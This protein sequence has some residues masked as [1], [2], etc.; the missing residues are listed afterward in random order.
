LEKN[1]RMKIS[2]TK[3]RIYSLAG[4]V[5]LIVLWELAAGIA[6]SGQLIPSPHETLIALFKIIIEKEFLSSFSITIARGLEGFL[7]SVLLA[8]LIG[9]PAGLY[10]GFFRFI[11]P[12]LVTVR[13][14]PIISLILLAII[15]FGSN[16]V[17]VFIAILTMFPV[18]TLNIIEGIK[19]VNNDLIE[20][21][22]VYKVKP[23]RVLKEVYIPSIAPYLTSGFSNALGFGWRAIIIGEVLSQ[24]KWGIGTQ[25]QKS[26]IFLKVDELIAWTLVAIMVS[27]IFEQCIRLAEKKLIRW[28]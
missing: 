15:W 2:I 27:Y 20:M 24:P 4:I 28:K 16:Q 1:F 13:S 19:N 9:I 17:P 12:L 6:G 10:E 3:N 23:V 11:N 22:D 7:F 25:M 21:S 14:T 5:T 26:Q 18:L 8:F